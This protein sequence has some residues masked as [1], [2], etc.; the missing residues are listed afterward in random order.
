MD[1]LEAV[2]NP[3]HEDHAN[4][5]RWYGGP[6]VPDDIAEKRIRMVLSMFADRR[7]G[8]L[9]SHRNGRRRNKG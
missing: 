9:M 7:K 8:P 2:L 5:L 4:Y 6:F 1:F 3:A